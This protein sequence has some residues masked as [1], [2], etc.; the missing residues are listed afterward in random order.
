MIDPTEADHL[1]SLTG[2]R[3]GHFGLES[4]FHGDVWLDDLDGIF[5]RPGDLAPHVAALA[6]RLR[7][8][9]PGAVC[10]PLT[11]GAFLA[12]LLARELDVE[13]CWTER[14]RAPESGVLFSA[15]YALPDGTSLA[16]RRV[17][18]VDDVVNAGSA[19]R[20][21]LDSVTA[22]GGEPVVVGA[23]LLLGPPDSRPTSFGRCR[24][25]ALAQADSNLW[26][27]AACPRCAAGEPLTALPT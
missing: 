2:A 17:A 24:V 19:V 18:V 22:G 10:G 20:A 21:T 4:G 3:T 13:F 8:Y 11:G 27:P 12:Q 25:E 6:G 5:R 16:G 9:D 26:E 7:A 23:L 1:L 15:E 14:A